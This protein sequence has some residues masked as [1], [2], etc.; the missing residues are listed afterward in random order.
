MHLAR[1]ATQ[2]AV[3]APWQPLGHV[4]T[5]GRCQAG[6]SMS[7]SNVRVQHDSSGTIQM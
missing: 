6:E 1:K 2:E 4:V 3:E 5:F 7:P